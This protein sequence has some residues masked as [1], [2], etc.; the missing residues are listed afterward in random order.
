MNY[1]VYI[2]SNAKNSPLYVGMTSNL[3]KRIWEHKNKLVE[4]SFT[5]KYNL[6]K[7][8][9]WEMCEDVNSIITRKKQL[10]NWHK[11][12]KLNLI[13]TT[14]PKLKDLSLFETYTDSET[15]SG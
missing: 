11:S 13:K 4:G 2:M 9:Y 6:T 5:S 7:L 12:W 3:E 1:Y 15:S 8:L 14:N 10:K